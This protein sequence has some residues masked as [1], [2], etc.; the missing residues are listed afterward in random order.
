MIGNIRIEICAGSYE[1]VCTA[2][3]FAEVDRIELNSALELGGMTPSLSAL[4]EAKKSSSKS[5]ICMTRPRPAGFR[6]TEREKDIM[7]KDAVQFLENGADGIVFGSLEDDLTIDIPFAEKMITLIHSY[8]KEAVF[9]KAFDLTPDPLQ[10][11]ETLISLKADRILTSG[12]KENV[13]EGLSVIR[14]LNEQSAGR[15]MILPGGG[16]SEKNVHDLISE[17]LCSEIHMS[18]KETRSDC[19]N[20]FA[21]S[22][23]RIRTVLNTLKTGTDPK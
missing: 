3:A 15:I 21:V 13:T 5:I 18:A 10:A 1:D 22:A 12:G 2:S 9:H 8:Q 16:V 11:M 20:Y 7:Y 23:E 17:G 6:Y 4:K 14:R 19:E